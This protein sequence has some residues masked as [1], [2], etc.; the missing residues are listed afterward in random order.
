M[1]MKY[2]K[3]R[4]QEDGEGMWGHKKEERG[5]EKNTGFVLPLSFLQATFCPTSGDSW[6]LLNSHSKKWTSA[7]SQRNEGEV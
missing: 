5:Q 3:E 4:K 7:K 2:D 1:A 6:S